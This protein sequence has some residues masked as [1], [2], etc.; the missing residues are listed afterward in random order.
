MLS[1]QNCH[2]RHRGS[3]AGDRPFRVWVCGVLF[4]F[5]WE[6][7]EKPA[8][9][10]ETWGF[11]DKSTFFRVHVYFQICNF[12]SIEVCRDRVCENPATPQKEPQNESWFG[13]NP[14]NVK[15]VGKP[16][17]NILNYIKTMPVLMWIAVC[18]SHVNRQ[19]GFDPTTIGEQA[20]TQHSVPT[21]VEW[22]MEL[23]CF[24][25]SYD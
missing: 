10:D 7:D 12:G 3:A 13:T 2:R 23:A 18:D 21:P 6:K 4:C 25:V 5:V 15:M 17:W 9:F 19:Y 14:S 8:D 22:V 11:G 1:L 16:M 20:N 24:L